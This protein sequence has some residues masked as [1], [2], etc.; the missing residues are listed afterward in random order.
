MQTHHTPIADGRP[1]VDETNPWRTASTET[2]YDNPWIRV[3]HRHVTTPTGTAG[4]YGHVHYK[5][6]GVGIIPI[7]AED[8]TWL[9]GQFR[10]AHDEYTWEIP[11]GGCPLGTDPIDTARRELREECG[12]LAHRIEPLIECSLSNSTTDERG[13]IFVA[14]DLESTRHDHDETERI[15][16]WRLPV[17]DAIDLAESGTITDSLSLIGLLRLAGIR[18]AAQH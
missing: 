16:L 7:D 18:R 12:L 13:A 15:E 3:S 17:Y 2:V 6:I 5:S 1:P 11:E 10:Y 9:V 4:L 8:H 14:T